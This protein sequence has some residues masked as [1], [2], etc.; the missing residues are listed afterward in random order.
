MIQRIVPYLTGLTVAAGGLEGA[1]DAGAVDQDALLPDRPRA[2]GKAG[3][4]LL[5]DGDVDLAEHTAD[6]AGHLLAELGI[7]VKE[8][9]LDAMRARRRAVAAP[10]PEA[11][12]VMTAAI[13][14][15]RCIALLPSANLCP[16][17]RGKAEA[18]DGE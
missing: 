6:L 2:P 15:S 8:R 1:P 13:E 11:P 10:R 9:D 7:K 3:L 17:R 14:A 18:G 4:D 16:I 12:P 5:S